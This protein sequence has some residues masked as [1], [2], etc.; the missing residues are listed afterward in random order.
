ME[1]DL[2]QRITLV[3]KTLQGIIIFILSFILGFLN[4]IWVKYV[5][6]FSGNPDGKDFAIADG[7]TNN[8]CKWL[9]LVLTTFATLEKK[10]L[11]CG[12]RL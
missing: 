1:M 6:R 8:I 2:T 12:A 5:R 7:K 11:A 10:A 3:L 9:S 4:N